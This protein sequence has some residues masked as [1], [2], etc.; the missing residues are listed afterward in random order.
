MRRK[1]HRALALA[2]GLLAVQPRRY[3]KWDADLTE[4]RKE[5]DRAIGYKVAC[6]RVGSGL[7]GLGCLGLVGLVLAMVG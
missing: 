4:M 1:T 3:Q 2:A 7:F 5:Y 6:F